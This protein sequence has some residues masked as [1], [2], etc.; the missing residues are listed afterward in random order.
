M[1][2]EERDDTFIP[3]HRCTLDP[4]SLHGFFLLLPVPPLS[5]EDGV[6]ATSMGAARV[7][8]YGGGQRSAAGFAIGFA[9]A[10]L[11]FHLP[12]SCRMLSR[13]TGPLP[14]P[15]LLP[16]F[17]DRYYRARLRRFPHLAKIMLKNCVFLPFLTLNSHNLGKAM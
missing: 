14:S 6:D 8:S 16:F 1:K 15:V 4:E 17:A 2:R 10:L 13:Q 7:K 12:P 9:V 5:R 11:P 3:F